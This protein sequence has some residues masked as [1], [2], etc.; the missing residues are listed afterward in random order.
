M[1]K[2]HTRSGGVGRSGFTLVELLV[3]IGIIAVLISILLPALGRV[4][5]QAKTSKC[6]ANL[7]Q[8][9]NALTMY[10]DENRG[11]FPNVDRDN[12]WKPW[13]ATFFGGSGAN[14]ATYPNPQVNNVHRHLMKYLNGKIYS[15]SQV[16]TM[17]GTQIFRCPGAVDFPL[18]SA[19]PGALSNTN[20]VFNGVLPYRKVTQIGRSTEI[21]AF[22]EGRYAWNASALRPYPLVNVAPGTNLA[23]VE[24][25]EWQWVESGISAGNNRIL[26][27]TLHNNQKSGAAVFIDGHVEVRGYKDLRP[28]DFGLSDSADPAQGKATDTYADILPPNQLRS[29]KARLN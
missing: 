3:V 28:L 14:P 2:G 7:R 8:M 5:D 9:G 17:P 6:L 10:I 16:Y 19:A 1:R 29:Y 27:F 22:S 4:R 13:S 23:N 25:A 21:I 26:N 11:H 18:A 15:G 24:Y 20:Y 12:S